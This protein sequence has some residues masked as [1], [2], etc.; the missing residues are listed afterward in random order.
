MAGTP[1]KAAA[2]LIC[3]HRNTAASFSTRLR[4]LIANEMEKA[5]P[6]AGEIEVD[7]SYPGGV[8]KGE[9]GRGAGGKVPVLAC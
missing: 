9:H 8:R 4:R 2:D 7:E 5:A 6:V 1:A 3:V